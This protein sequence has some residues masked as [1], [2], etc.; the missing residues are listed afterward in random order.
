MSPFRTGSPFRVAAF[1]AALA[2]ALGMAVSG[3]GGAGSW[4]AA[5]VF[6]FALWHHGRLWRSARQPLPPEISRASEWA[7]VEPLLKAKVAFLFK[8]SPACPV[9]ARAA[10]EVRSFA[11]SKPGVPVVQLDVLAARPLS[12]RVAQVL[13]VTHES[14]QVI[15]L[16]GG[17]VLR[18]LN[19][20]SVRVED[21]RQALASVR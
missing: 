2:V 19:H 4:I 15:V 16:G 12:S 21:L 9:S 10:G 11:R 8:H 18:V 20:G 7:Q 17:T 13:E 14:P 6:A 1:A 5:A 3:V